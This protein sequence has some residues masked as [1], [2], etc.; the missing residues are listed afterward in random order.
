[1]KN[2]ILFIGLF[3]ITGSVPALATRSG[4]PGTDPAWISEKGYWVVQTN[5]NSPQQYTVLF[6]SKENK[7]VYRQEMKGRKLNPDKR[8]TKMK[9][10]RTLEEALAKPW[11]NMGEA[12]QPYFTTSL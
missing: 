5:A 6:Y 11:T 3:I 1:M 7:L 4:K 9:L 2:V 8:K 12:D 10:K